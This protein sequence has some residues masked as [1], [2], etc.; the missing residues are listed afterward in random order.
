MSSQPSFYSSAICMIKK[1]LIFI[2]CSPLLFTSGSNLTS[3]VL[4]TAIA[5]MRIYITM[6]RDALFLHHTQKYVG[7]WS[8]C[9]FEKR[10]TLIHNLSLRLEITLIF[11]RQTRLIYFFGRKWTQAQIMK[12]ERTREPKPLV[13]ISYT[14]ALS[15]S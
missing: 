5:M 7:N 13:V 14:S 11:I 2:I 9:G 12:T 15:I 4:L 6:H 10:E 3:S 1:E 8:P